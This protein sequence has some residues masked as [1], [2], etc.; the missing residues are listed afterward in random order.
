MRDVADFN[1]DGK[2][3][4]PALQCW[5]AANS[6]LVYEQQRF[7]ERCIWPDSPGRL[8]PGQAVIPQE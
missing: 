2:P 8:E 1:R 5:D 3:D 6:D 7:R 4:Y